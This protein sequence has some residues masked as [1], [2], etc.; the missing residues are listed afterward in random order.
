[1]AVQ[2]GCSF[3][4][5]EIFTF[6][7]LADLFEGFLLTPREGAST[8]IYGRCCSVDVALAAA[9]PTDAAAAVGPKDAEEAFR[10]NLELREIRDALTLGVRFFLTKDLPRGNA[11]KI[12]VD[13]ASK[14]LRL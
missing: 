13:K 5:A 8:V 7:E 4:S 1:M 6:T 12:F 11:G 2:L 10:D 9:A 3:V 14:N